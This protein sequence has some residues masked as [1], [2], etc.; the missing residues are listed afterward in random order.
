LNQV[1][2]LDLDQY[3]EPPKTSSLPSGMPF[4]ERQMLVLLTLSALP[5]RK[6]DGVAV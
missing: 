5:P 2:K 4:N 3:L 6:P 1:S